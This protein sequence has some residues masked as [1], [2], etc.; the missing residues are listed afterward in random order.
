[1][2][3]RVLLLASMVTLLWAAPASAQSYGNTLNQSQAQVV[4][5]PSGPVV[6]QAGG[7][8]LAHTGSSTAVPLVQTGIV[9]LGGG[10]LLVR[11]G[12]RRRRTA[13]PI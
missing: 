9:L 8:D 10:A 13:R 11:V 3:R 2:V 12:R 5:S 4:V 6:A 7:G 1:M